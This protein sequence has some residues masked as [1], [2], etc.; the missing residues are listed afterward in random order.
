MWLL[1]T[2]YAIV[3][4]PGVK[5]DLRY[6]LGILNSPILTSF[7][8]ET[9]TALRGG[10]FRMKTAYLTPFPIRTID[11]ANPA[12]VNQHD[13]LVRL[14]GQMLALHQKMAAAGNPADKQM[15]QRQIAMTDRAIDRLVYG[16]Y[17]L[18]EEEIKIVEASGG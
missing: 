9:G 14:V 11:F 16:L 17:N 6:I 12:E 4:K 3:K 18:G 7:L 10:Y 1:D 15:Y 13:E 5:I 8:K 2:A